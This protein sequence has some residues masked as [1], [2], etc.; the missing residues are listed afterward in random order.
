MRSTKHIF[1]AVLLSA[2]VWSA[3]AQQTAKV[4]PLEAK[5]NASYASLLYADAMSYYKQVHKTAP[6]TELAAKIADC[7]W[8]LRN[9]DSAYVWYAKLPQER[10]NANRQEQVRLA[11][12]TATM[13]QYPQA[14]ASLRNV[15]GY[16]PR[17][18]GFTNTAI[19]VRD[20]AQWNVQYLSGINTDYFREFSPVLVDTGL[21]WTTNQ[22]KTFGQNGIMGWDKMGYNRLLK[23]TDLEQLKPE[24]IKGRST[25]DLYADSNR[26]VR[27]AKHYTMADVDILSSAPLK[28]SLLRK[29]SQIQTIAKPVLFTD[30]VK[31][32]IAHASYASNDKTVLVSVNQQGKTGGQTRMLSLASATLNGAVMSNVHYVLQQT[33]AYSNMH[34]AIHPNGNLVVFSSNREGGKG[35][36]DLYMIT[37][38]ENGKWSEA[39]LVQGV[40]TVGNELFPTFGADGKFYF[41]SDAHPGLGGLDIYVSTF[42]NGRVKSIKHLS[43]PVNSAYDDF[44][45]TITADGSKGYFS[46]DRLGTDD[47]YMFEKAPKLVMLSGR[48]NSLATK[49]GKPGVTVTLIEKP[50]NAKAEGVNVPL[51]I[52]GSIAAP[53]APKGQAGTGKPSIIGTASAEAVAGLAT[54]GSWDINRLAGEELTISPDAVV[55]GPQVV[56]T[57]ANGNYRFW[58]KPNRSYDIVISD[59][60]SPKETMAINTYGNGNIGEIGAV[61]MHDIVP[62]AP[63]KVFDT[64]KFIVYFAFD[65]DEIRKRYADTLDQVAALM[66]ANTEVVCDLSGHTDQYGTD[67]Y[68]DDLSSRR[69][70]NVKAYLIKAGIAAERLITDSYGEKK[71]IQAIKNKKKAEINRRVE[72]IIRLAN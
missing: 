58:V 31:Y 47:V 25:A 57:D 59:G 20:S 5:G 14:S 11:E 1:S 45:V 62:E 39:N 55:S 28:P 43:Y 36:Y 63:K 6:S 23:V 29:L 10:L 22:P 33:A 7:Y 13:G 64:Q 41:S 24:A 15:P 71:L 40:N 3:S 51:T 16:R 49:A 12:L 19:M 65:K 38:D 60:N 27:L 8:L 44:G 72:I 50:D 54:I 35:G 68:N 4:S 53:T 18:T 61:A 67:G 9:Y 26:P 48:V 17:A 69:V 34:P 52:S 21:I 37:K 56:T 32:N 2:T 66:K 42:D 30:K 70:V 46:S